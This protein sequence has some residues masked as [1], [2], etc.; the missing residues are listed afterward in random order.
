MAQPIS[1]IY[2]SFRRT[3]KG[4]RGRGVKVMGVR[5][6]LS[7]GHEKDWDQSL[8]RPSPPKTTRCGVCLQHVMIAEMRQGPKLEGSP[9]NGAT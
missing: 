1:N 4:W 9:V 5:L 6:M 2:S 8:Q 7:C 3:V